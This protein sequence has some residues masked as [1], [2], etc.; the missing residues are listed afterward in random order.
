[1]SSTVVIV[2]SL[3]AGLFLV[4]GGGLIMYMSNLVKA[5][6]ALKIE[7]N[8][9]LESNF[10]KM[11]EDIEKRIKW[12]KKDMVDEVEKI[13]IALQADT[14]RKSDEFTGTFTGRIAKLEETVKAEQAEVRK[15][16]EEDR[17]ALTILDKKLNVLRRELKQGG[18]APKADGA[19]A[20]AATDD[21]APAATPA[22]PPAPPI[23][24]AKPFTPDAV[25][26]GKVN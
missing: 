25:D 14:E 18:K 21:G 16:F 19:D 6:Y 2:M 5:A 26:E 10:K 15:A 22:E 17:Q 3:V 7:L 20:E 1:M 23:A 9:E 4:V 12:V 24:T 8:N 11:D 13:K